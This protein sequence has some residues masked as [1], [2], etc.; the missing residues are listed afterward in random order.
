MSGRLRLRSAAAGAALWTSALLALP[1]GP[2]GA[3]DAGGLV[4]AGSGAAG[5]AATSL[6]SF[7]LQS[8]RLIVERS[9][10]LAPI[11]TEGGAQL[12]LEA[13]IAYEPGRPQERVLGLRARLVGREPSALAYLDLHEVEDLA[14]SLA[15]VPGVLDLERGNPGELSIHYVSR[16]GFGVTLAVKRAGVQRRLRFARPEPI[17]VGLS[18][19][20][21]TEL[22]VQL[23][24]SRRYLFGK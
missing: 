3:Q 20:A 19:A 23:D 21:L 12:A 5:A 9:E 4:G 1:G 22:R 7:L 24:G 15:A 10:A 6:E 8:D 18:E 13:V 2:A 11:G 17:E 16:D 14:R